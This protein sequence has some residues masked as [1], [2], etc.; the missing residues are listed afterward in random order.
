MNETHQKNNEHDI[1]NILIAT[2]D[3]PW[4]GGGVGGKHTHIRLLIKGLSEVGVKTDLATVKETVSFRCMRLYP[5]SIKHRIL[6]SPRQVRYERYVSRYSDELLR[7]LLKR[8]NDSHEIVNPH[9]VIAVKGALDAYER[10][11]REPPPIVLTLHGYYSREACSVGE[12]PEESPQYER[13]M[14]LERAMYEKTSRIVCVDSRIRRYV[15]DEA[16]ICDSRVTVLANAVD[17]SGFVPIEDMKKNALRS[18]L[19]LPEDRL[20]ILCPRRL[21]PKNG[22]LYAVSAMKQVVKSVPDA[23]LILAGSGPQR[24][25][26]ESTAKSLGLEN[27]VLFSGS[28]PHDKIGGFY[29]ASDIV[30]VPSILSSGVEEA[31]SLSM[32]EGMACGKPV[33]VTNVGGLKETVVD[34]KTGIIVPDKDADAIAAA[35]VRLWN[36]KELANDLGVGARLYIERNHSYRVHT[37]RML[38]QCR[39]ALETRHR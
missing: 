15:L 3:D 10:K 1:R 37:E 13:A 18:S 21:V 20:M 26:I 8:I 38:E 23:L 9:D 5:G 19:G 7:S 28:I 24:R 12:M 6:R 25:E 31:T 29:S 16:D 22:V 11:G 32:L 39:L 33:I 27:N 36:D 14:A 35:A 34:G 4:K 2:A 30:L 17:T